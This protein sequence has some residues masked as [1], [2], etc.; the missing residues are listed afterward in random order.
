MPYQTIIAGLLCYNKLC[1]TLGRLGFE[2]NPYKPCVH[3]MIVNGKQQTV[4]F[5]VNNLKSSE[6]TKTNDALVS[7]LR[8]EYDYIQDDG[9]DNMTVHQG[10]THEYL[11]MTLD[12]DTPGVYGVS[13]K[14]YTPEIISDAEKSMDICKGVKT[15]A[16]P[17]DLF[18]VNK[19]SPKLHKEKKESFHS[20]VTKILFATKW[21]HPIQPHQSLTL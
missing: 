8:S 7:E 15:S 3:H 21:A 10:K 2:P 17:K 13:M 18:V 19:E 4:C 1:A 20:L 14:K 12:Y 16:A 6:Q 9:T 5:H 11:G